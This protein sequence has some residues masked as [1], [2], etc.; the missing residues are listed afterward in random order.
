MKHIINEDKQPF[1]LLFLFFGVIT[2][3][4]VT[5]LSHSYGQG[6]SDRNESG[7][8][9]DPRPVTL[10]DERPDHPWNHAHRVLFIRTD[11][12]G[13]EYGHD[14]ANPPLFEDSRYLLQSPR[15]ENAIEALEAVLESTS[16]ISKQKPVERALFQHDM[17][18]LYDWAVSKNKPHPK[19][20]KKMAHLSSRV[21]DL[22]ALKKKQIENLPN[23]Y[24]RTV[25]SG[26]YSTDFDKN[27]PALPFLPPEL[28]REKG[29]WIVLGQKDE[30]NAIS[31]TTSFEARSTFIVLLNLPG[32]RE[33]TLE[34]IKRAN[35]NEGVWDRDNIFRSERVRFTAP[36]VPVGTKLALLRRMNVVDDQGEPRMTPITMSLQMRV[37]PKEDSSRF[38]NQKNVFMFKMIRRKLL[39]SSKESLKPLQPDERLLIQ[40]TF[41][42]SYD[43]FDGVAPSIHPKLSMCFHCHVDGH[44]A[45]SLMTFQDHPD[46]HPPAVLQSS[47]PGEARKTFKWKLDQKEWNDLRQF[48]RR[49]DQDQR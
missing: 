22:V 20:R 41:R 39:G 42:A 28:L 3:L 6:T 46:A 1:L 44:N 15:Y 4:L 12:E 26:A 10:Y 49:A 9:I 31:H 8:G 13:R 14:R 5:Y 29:P 7:P 36:S 33:A 45:R 34:W 43:P 25:S 19:R 47:I 30:P 11:E 24:T 18:L 48:L 21:M 2:G 27:N 16:K 17:W 23:N 40:N 37:H 32:G 35:E 38:M